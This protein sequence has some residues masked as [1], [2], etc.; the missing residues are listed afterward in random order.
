VSDGS[1]LL[2]G[3]P[4]SGKTTIAEQMAAHLGR[5]L[6]IITVSD[7][8]AGGAAEV[9]ARAKQIFEVLLEQQNVIILL[10]EIDQFLLDRNGDDYKKQQGIFQFMTPGMLTKLQDLK[11]AKRSIFIVG[12]NYA[13]RIDSAIK[14]QGRIEDRHLLNIPDSEQRRRLVYRFLKK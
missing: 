11:D 7:F 1:I 9:E 3:P 5:R 2:Y 14:R 4:G 13:E 6:I 10:D 8:L 12:T